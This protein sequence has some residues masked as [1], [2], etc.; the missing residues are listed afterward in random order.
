MR[1]QV[2][3]VVTVSDAEILAAIRLIMEVGSPMPC[4]PPCHIWTGTGTDLPLKG[5]IFHRE[6]E[7]RLFCRPRE[8]KNSILN[9]F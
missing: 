4:L 2:D 8:A 9:E 1:L 3:G 6:A 7:N 5:Q